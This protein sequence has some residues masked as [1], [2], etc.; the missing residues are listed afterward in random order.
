MVPAFAGLGAPHWDAD[1]RGAPI[2][3][4]RGTG[5]AEIARAALESVAWQTRTC[6]TPCAPTGRTM[7]NA[8]LRVD[9]GMTVSAWTMRFLADAL[10]CPGRRAG[11]AETTALG[12]AYLAGLQAGLCPPPGDGASPGP[13]TGSGASA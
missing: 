4:T 7:G 12:A 5:R 6:W 2:G 9:G 13:P 3:L 11:D 8:V 1:A 10:E